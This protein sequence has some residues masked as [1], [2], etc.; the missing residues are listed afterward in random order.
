MRYTPTT[1]R[2]R[3][4]MLAAIGVDSVDAL[5]EDIP[6]WLRFTGRLAIPPPLSEPE[7]L[8][9]LGELAARNASFATSSRSSAPGMYDHH[10]PPVVE[11]IT[12][13]SEF[14][15]AYTPY[16]PEVTRAR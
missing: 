3:A 6:G 11:R 9:D 8:R 10:V 16:Q 7:L 1:D 5:F 15:T 14:Q 4:E 13:R 2:D 12:G